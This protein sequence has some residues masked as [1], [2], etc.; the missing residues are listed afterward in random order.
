MKSESWK[1]VTEEQF[2]NA[3]APFK[4]TLTVHTIGFCDPPIVFYWNRKPKPGD[5]WSFGKE[6][7]AKKILDESTEY[8]L[9]D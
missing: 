5:D 6:S 7:F 2:K 4:D 9:K 8:Y 1:K 3:I